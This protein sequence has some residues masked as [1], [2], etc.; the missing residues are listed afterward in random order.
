LFVIALRKPHA[1]AINNVDGG[2]DFNHLLVNQKRFFTFAKVGFF[3][4]REKKALFLL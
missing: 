1:L 3:P 4:Q 2:D